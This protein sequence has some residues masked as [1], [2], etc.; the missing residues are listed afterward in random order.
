MKHPRLESINRIILQAGHGGLQGE[1]YDPGAVDPKTG[2]RENIE[3]KQIITR[4]SHK[5]T[6]NGLTVVVTPDFGLKRA[7]EFINANYDSNT[8][9][10]FEIH[11]DSAANF[12]DKMI[13]RMGVYYHPDS[14]GSKDIA[15]VLV[16]G[17]KRSGANPTSW[18]RS[19]TDSNHGSLG[20]IRRTKMLAHLVE[21]GF[22]EDRTDDIADEFFAEA[23]SKS[24]CF[25][26]EINFRK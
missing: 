7:V 11:K 25:A 10:A 3:V 5:L 20:W 4:L 21:A 18:A 23:I 24:I 14:Y 19:D 2:A 15:E 9:W 13:K 8:D 1:N 26:L 22:I 16:D 12:N 6:Q 17:F